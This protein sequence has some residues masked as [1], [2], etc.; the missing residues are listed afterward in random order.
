[1]YALKWTFFLAIGLGIG[2]AVL[3]ALLA[4][5]DRN[6]K[7]PPIDAATPSISVIIPAYNEAKVI[8]SSVRRVLASDYPALELIVADD[9]SSDGT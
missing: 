6:R 4:I 7:P 8:E 5:G 3:I 9:G 2:R 1:A